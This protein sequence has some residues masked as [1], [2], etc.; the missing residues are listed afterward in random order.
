M[1]NDSDLWPIRCPCGHTT[2]AGIGWLWDRDTFECER[3]KSEFAFDNKRFRA[4]VERTR[5]HVESV[6][7]LDWSYLGERVR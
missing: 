2:Q 1:L 4:E 6:H 5:K 7:N 3:C